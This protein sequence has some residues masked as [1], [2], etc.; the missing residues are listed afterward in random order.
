MIDDIFI[1]E[2]RLNWPELFLGLILDGISMRD[3][4]PKFFNSAYMKHVDNRNP[5]YTSMQPMRQ[6]TYDN[7]ERLFENTT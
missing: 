7:I 3:F 1:M 5:Y 4:L 6:V 2:L